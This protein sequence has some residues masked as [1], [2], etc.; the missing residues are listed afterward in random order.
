M[1]SKDGPTFFELIRQAL[2]STQQG[3]DLLAPK[4]DATP[5]R[6]P[7]EMI[8]PAIHAIGE[9]DSA[10]DVCCGTGAGMRLLRPICRQNVVGIDFSPGMLQQAK[11][12]LEKAKG[13]AKV[14]FVEAD[15]MQMTFQEEFDVVTCFGRAGPY[16]TGRGERLSAPDSPGTQT[17]RAFCVLFRLSAASAVPVPPRAAKL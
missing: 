5:F 16:F 9:A 14:E 10:L 17:W 3:Y 15:V 1:F 8:E 2:S 12:K 11:Q 4:F 7:D 6:T 13:T